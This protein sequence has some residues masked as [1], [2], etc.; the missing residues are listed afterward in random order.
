MPFIL[1]QSDISTV[2]DVI[3][4][5]ILHLLS[6]PLSCMLVI[7]LLMFCCTV[8]KLTGKPNSLYDAADGDEDRKFL[9]C[10]YCCMQYRTL[11][12]HC[13]IPVQLCFMSLCLFSCFYVLCRPTDCVVVVFY[14]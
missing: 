7:N 9:Y 12:S 14:E 8:H 13:C 4:E 11:I 3:A 5:V 6:V 2:T 10:S 1:A